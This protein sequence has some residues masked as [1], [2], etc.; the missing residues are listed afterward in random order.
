MVLGIS[1]PPVSYFHL[2]SILF[3]TSS[4]VLDDRDMENH[5]IPLDI[6]P[7]IFIT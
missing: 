5:V 2:F 1:P 6:L 3:L 4:T 7:K